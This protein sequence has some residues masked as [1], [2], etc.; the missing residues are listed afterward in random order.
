MTKIK[1]RDFVKGLPAVSFLPFITEFALVQKKDD[2]DSDT[3]LST[4]IQQNDERI[5]LRVKQQVKD[6]EHKWNGIILNAHGI[7]SP[8]GTAGYIKELISA[9]VSSESKYYKDPAITEYMNAAT[10]GLLR[11]QYKDGTIDLLSTNFHSPPDTAFV[12]EPLAIAYNILQKHEDNALSGLKEGLQQ[13]LINAGDA[14]KMGGIHTPNHRWVVCMALSRI[15][16]LFP[17]PDYI[18][19]TDRWLQEK[20]DIDPDGQYTEKSTLIYTPLTNRCLITIAR[21]LDKPELFEPV[22]KN[23]NMSLF[24]VH[25]NGE[26][27]TEAS[28]RQDQ[29][30][31]GFMHNYYYPYRYMA[32]KE[33]NGQFTA[34]EQ[35]VRSAALDRLTHWLGYFLEDNMLTKSL[36]KATPLPKNY[37][38]V[39]S[40]SNLVRIRRDKSDATIIGKNPIFFTFYKG[41]AV[42]EGIRLASAFFGKGQFQTSMIEKEEENFILAQFLSA[43]Y[44]QP[45]PEDEIPDDG[46]WDKMPRSNREQSEIQKLFTQIIVK[47]VKSGHFDI[48]ISIEGTDNVPLTI[49]LGFRKNG[50]LSGVEELEDVPDSFLLKEVYGSFTYN[51]HTIRFGPGVADHQWTQLRGALPKL[52]A[53]SVYITGFTPFHHT[54]SIS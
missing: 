35:L 13:F 29:Y 28:G 16:Q 45:Y 5:P 6:P 10:R 11:M 23:L 32:I 51:G 49:E 37:L 33:N 40:H 48:D 39:F 18:K 31:R 17:D 4:L 36:P 30:Q 38:K 26:V 44:Y 47:E 21:L 43:P 34:M 2:P 22:R 25:P 50:V 7:P 20:I 24:Y 53:S 1:R 27:V 46:D 19:R 41:D 3:V 15:N 52:N 14:L 54:I 12:V 8:M 9:Y 42:L